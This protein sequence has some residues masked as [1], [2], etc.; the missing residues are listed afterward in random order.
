MTLSR[1]NWRSRRI[2]LR[3]VP[4]NSTPKPLTL[5]PRIECLELDLREGEAWTL[6]VNPCEKILPK[7]TK[8]WEIAVSCIDYSTV[9]SFS[10]V[11][12]V[13]F[14]PMSASMRFLIPAVG[15]TSGIC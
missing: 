5:L 8:A 6:C 3:G 7:S 1:R 9:S 10:L 2:V 15:M 12:L 14:L 13:V 4:L 11:S